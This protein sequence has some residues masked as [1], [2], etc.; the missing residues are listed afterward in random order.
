MQ[1]FRSAT[2]KLTAWY[3]GILMTI[4]IIFSIAIYQISFHEVNVRL[5][6]LQNNL[7]NTLGVTA[8]PK[9]DD[10]I[11][12][13]QSD[14]AA[15]QMIWSLTII[16]AVILVGG[17]AGS[18]WLARRTLRPLEQAHEA[19]ARFTSD[20]SHELRTPLAAIKT[21]IEVMLRDPK[22]DPD[23]ARELLESN[24]EE[25]DNI[26]QVSEMLLR[27]SHLDDDMIEKTQVNLT[28]TLNNTMKMF[29]SSSK[30]F[31]IEAAKTVVATGNKAAISE[32]M[33]ILIDNALKYSTPD[34]KIK[35][36]LFQETLV[37]GFEIT[38]SGPTINKKTV[39]H[40]FERFYR[41]DSSRTKG[42]ENGYG[43]GLSI[44]KKI[45]DLHN[46]EIEVTSKNGSTTFRWYL[47]NIKSRQP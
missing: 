21:E 29:K 38:N 36:R 15:L 47:P 1:S 42:S 3:L 44:A 7:Y 16:N 39:D 22:I 37:A 12:R 26:I 17:G 30:R 43:L 20:A 19:Q 18:Y 45:V 8:E 11:R 24:L 6:N 2:L 41:G 35:I 33:S 27:L 32:L 13:I 5:E 46:G 25:V 23:E 40:I 10:N 4:S 34:S 28:A 9:V 14:Q 31:D